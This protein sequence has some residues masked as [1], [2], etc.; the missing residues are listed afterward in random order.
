[1]SRA[2]LREVHVVDARAGGAVG[3]ARAA[4]ERVEALRDDCLRSIPLV[5]RPLVPLGELLARRWL[6]RSASPYLAEIDA[7][8]ALLGKS[9]AWFLNASYQWGCTTLAREEE[10]PPWLARTLDWPFHGLGRHL[11]IVR[12][13]GPAGEFFSVTWP[14][15]VGTLTAMAPGRFAAAM[16]QAPLKRRTR[17]PWLRLVDVAVNAV[18]TYT[19]VRHI[20]PDQL[21]RQVFQ[22]CQ[23]FDAARRMLEITPVARPVIFTL[24]GCR[25]GERC[26][27]ERTEEAHQTHFEDTCIANDWLHPAEPWEG[28]IAAELVVHATFA[29]AAE[30]SRARRAAL[31]GWNGRLGDDSFAWV[32]PPV[33]NPCT[34]LAVEMC[35][36]SGLLRAVG[37]E[38][39]PGADLPARATQVGEVRAI[40]GAA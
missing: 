8:A 31:Q 18:M 40:A 20:P 33:L 23:N 6:R 5:L 7:I 32:T 35:A 1:M 29:Q 28:R 27:I 22:I 13:Q 24:A 19:R 12:M 36:A 38:L 15:Y 39:E 34:R 30:N 16:N 11:D 37:Y 25:P 10:G 9:G 3:H 21:L 2:S 26:V 17:H 14:G 4:P